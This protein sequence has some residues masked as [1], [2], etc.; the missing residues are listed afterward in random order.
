[1]KWIKSGGGPL[2]FIE[3]ELAGNW[4]GVT[5]SSLLRSNAGE[6]ETD[7][8]RG[9]QVRDYLG[10]VAVGTDNACILG[11][12]PRETLVWNVRGELPSIVRV[13]YA[14]PDVDVTELLGEKSYLDFDDPTEVLHLK[15]GSTPMVIFDSACPGSS[16]DIERLLFDIPTGK[17]VVLTKQF[18]LDSRTAVLVHAFK[19]FQ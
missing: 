16:L 14:D 11:D 6:M 7:Y 9:C 3:R 5:G 19:S 1:M 4:L 18:D 8:E 2:L 10:Q 12:M 15:I 17:Y 13:L